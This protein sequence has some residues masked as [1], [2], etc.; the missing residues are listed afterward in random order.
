[1]DQTRYTTE[2]QDHEYV[3]SKVAGL[4][5]KVCSF[6][7]EEGHVTM[8]YPFVPFHIKTNITRHVKL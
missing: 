2:T 1:M 5:L 3:D 6:C 8:D 7:E 4:L